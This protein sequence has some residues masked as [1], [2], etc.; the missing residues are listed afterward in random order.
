MIYNIKGMVPII[1]NE[2]G[3]N[4]NTNIANLKSF[5][6]KA[7]VQNAPKDYLH[8]LGYAEK[9]QPGEESKYKIAFPNDRAK[10]IG[11]FDRKEKY[12]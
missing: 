7:A 1:T 9:I 6:P 5:L 8:K 2:V 4:V 12:K 10:S 3:I 11:P